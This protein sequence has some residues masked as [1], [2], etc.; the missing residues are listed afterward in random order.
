MLTH[1]KLF[2]FVL[3]LAGLL[4][5]CGLL[6]P[7]RQPTEDLAGFETQI[8]QEVSSQLTIS[9]A[10][11]R[12]A[13]QTQQAFFTPTATPSP[14]I[15]P[16][17][18]ASLTP[19]PPP[20]TSTIIILPTATRIP[21]TPIPCNWVGFVKDVTIK[22]GSRIE[23]QQSFTKT[24]RL[25][26]KGTCKWTREYALV[27][28]DGS[29]MSGPEVQYL[30]TQ[31]K[32]GQTVD[33][34]VK[35][36]APKKAGE[37]AGYWMLSDANGRRFG[38]GSRAN[39]PFWV[40]IKAVVPAPTP[41][42]TSSP[43]PTPTNQPPPCNRA[44]FVTDVTVPDYTLFKPGEAFTKIWR[45][46]NT[47]ACKWTNNYGLSF[48]SGDQMQGPDLQYIGREVKPG[49]LIDVAVNL[50]APDKPGD[51]VGNWAFRDTN[52]VIFGIGSKGDKPFWVKIRVAEVS[53]HVFDFA[54]RY[55][56]ADW[57]SRAGELNCPHW[58]NS[59]QRIYKDNGK[60]PLEDYRDGFFSYS[61]EPR[62]E[63]PTEPT[64]PVLVVRPDNQPDGYI[65]GSFPGLEITSSYRFRTV[66][67]C[68]QEN[69]ACDVTFQLNYRLA[70][71]QVQVLA[72]WREVFD[73][74]VT[75]QDI[76]LSF[77]AG[78]KVW[79]DL[80]VVNN[81]DSKHDWAFW[82]YPRIDQVVGQR[83]ED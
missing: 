12:I 74:K 3:I 32:P 73:G 42:V 69:P 25:A 33:L 4:A 50:V 16:T 23:V 71:G 8:A 61:D 62:L 35:L 45:F 58:Q 15:T 9:A 7:N 68:M 83:T 49:E 19:L 2:I 56:D 37:Y 27:F 39:D 52:G 66:T 30:E 72:F 51:H 18:T 53:T 1:K 28:V 81:G 11:T 77:L 48:V 5:G 80:V 67:G 26:N 31:V 59:G 79:F 38:L 36:K 63:A 40:K 24:W 13:E 43:T 6:R 78:Q 65:T 21:P 34:S 14:T 64:G 10:F 57:K 54:E 46:K 70:D 44:E 22:D 75:T 17:P 20:P 82:L 76:D 29:R 55:C 60:I 41:T 47:G